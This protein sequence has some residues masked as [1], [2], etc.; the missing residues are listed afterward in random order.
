MRKLLSMWKEVVAMFAIEWKDRQPFQ[1]NTLCPYKERIYFIQEVEEKLI[2]RISTSLSL[3][4][5]GL[6]NLDGHTYLFFP[7]MGGTSYHDLCHQKRSFEASLYLVKVLLY[8]LMELKKEQL[9]FYL[10]KKTIYFQERFIFLVGINTNLYDVSENKRVMYLVGSLILDLLD[11][12]DEF[13]SKHIHPNIYHFIEKQEGFTYT[14]LQEILE[15]ILLLDQVHQDKKNK[16]FSHFLKIAGKV[17]LAM[18]IVL[19]IAV[20][21]IPIMYYF[22]N[23][24]EGITS[25]GDVLLN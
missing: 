13:Q 10:D 12:T 17:C 18:S 14:S 8:E 16:K 3:P 7:Y 15:D 5:V 6:L 21:V 4:E 24:T 19:S 1:K 20:M 23:S 25:I 9:I 22:M 2:Q 11:N